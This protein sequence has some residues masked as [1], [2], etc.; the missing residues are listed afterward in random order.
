MGLYSC[1]HVLMVQPS[2][3]PTILPPCVS[4]PMSLQL[5]QSDQ[6]GRKTS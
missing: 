4:S 3:G 6:Q 2:A 5:S 1:Q